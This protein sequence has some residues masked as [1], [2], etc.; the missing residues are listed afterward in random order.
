MARA[1][2][3]HTN[4]TGPARSGRPNDTARPVFTNAAACTRFSGVMRF[5]DPIWSFSPHLPQL[6]R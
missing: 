2:L 3:D 4:K 1:R 5:T 6:R